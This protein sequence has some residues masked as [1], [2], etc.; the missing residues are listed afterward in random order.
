M[1]AFDAH[2]EGSG[3]TLRPCTFPD[4][5]DFIE[6]A[7]TCRIADPMAPLIGVTVFRT[8]RESQYGAGARQAAEGGRRYPHQE[9]RTIG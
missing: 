7:G 4:G 6:T 8:D 3:E 5:V 1:E 2:H 9:V